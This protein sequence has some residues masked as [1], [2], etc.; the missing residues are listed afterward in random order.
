MKCIGPA[1]ACFFM[2]MNLCAQQALPK[3]FSREFQEQYTQKELPQTRQVGVNQ[4]QLAQ[5][6]L[7]HQQSPLVSFPVSLSLNSNSSGKW[8][9]LKDGS[10]IWQLRL[11]QPSAQALAIS[12]EQSEMPNGAYFYFFDPLGKTIIG[13]ITK[14]DFS[15]NRRLFSGVIPGEELVVEYFEPKGISRSGNFEIFRMDHIY[16]TANNLGDPRFGTSLECHTNINCA[17]GGDFQNE[18]LGICR[19]VM[20]LEEGIGYCSGNL[21]NN[22]AK[23]QTPYILTGFHCQDGFTP[24]YDLWRFDFNFEAEGCGD[25]DIAPD[26]QSMTGCVQRAGRQESDMLLLELNEKI[27]GSY[28]VFYLGWDRSEVGPSMSTNIHHP[29]GDIKKITHF[30]TPATIFNSPINWDNDVQ[31]PARQ[32]FLLSFNDGTFELGSSGSA[33]LNQEGMVVG[34]LHGGIASCEDTKGYFGRFHLDWTGDE[35]RETRLR[36]WLD[37]LNLDSQT[38]QGLEPP[39][40]PGGLI[41]GSILMEDGQGIPEITVQLVGVNGATTSTDNEGG[42]DFPNTPFD[43]EFQI[44]LTKVDD[45]ANG[46]SLGDIIAI[47]K[48]IL[49]S[50]LIDS[51]YKMIAADANGSGHISLA[52]IIPNSKDH[53]STRTQF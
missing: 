4:S 47:Q 11:Y 10:R 45:A 28:R 26:F 48:H 25:P 41:S 34:H 33:L 5:H 21:M 8:F 40:A 53:S 37:P 9:K 16:K 32:H 38:L 2:V 39:F 6:Q 51:P 17:A 29:F 13:P 27:P 50:Q 19:I 23:D 46:V 36:D 49:R 14:K 12:L 7:Q 35:T 42:F 43:Q 1:L 31:T 18:K 24:I 44:A 30:Y 20:V 22:T 15:E 52:D 3:S